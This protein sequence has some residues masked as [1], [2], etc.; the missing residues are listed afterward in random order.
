MYSSKVTWRSSFLNQS[1]FD[2]FLAGLW[3]ISGSKSD[4]A[5]PNQ[6]EWNWMNSNI[7]KWKYQWYIHCQSL[8]IHWYFN[9]NYKICSRIRSRTV[10]YPSQNQFH[11]HKRVENVLNVNFHEYTWISFYEQAEDKNVFSKDAF[12]KSNLPK[13]LKLMLTSKRYQ[14]IKWRH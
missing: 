14:P 12:W 11:I 3:A 4:L 7:A 6:I 10:L 8:I 1:T 13:V 5:D 9:L 2:W